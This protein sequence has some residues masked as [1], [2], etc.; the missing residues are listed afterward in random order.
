MIKGIT[1]NIERKRILAFSSFVFLSSLSAIIFTNIDKLMLGYFIQAEFIGYYTAIFSVI[2]GLL[3]LF[4]LSIVVFPVFTQIHGKRLKRAFHKTFHYLFMLT[5]PITI[6]L[7]YIFIPII[8]ILYGSVYVPLEYRTTLTITSVFLSF[9]FLE[10]IITGLYA[11]LFN[12][13]EK[14][15]L[16]ALTMIIVAILNIILNFILISY[17]IRFRPEYGLIGAAIATFASR[18]IYLGSLFVLG[19]TKLNIIPNKNSIIK[20]LTASIIMLAFL[21]IFDY[22]VPLNIFY[23]II[24]VI[25]AALIYLLIM[26]L[27]KGIKKEDIGLLIFFRKN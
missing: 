24:M 12:A 21:F 13:K 2:S 5:F 10:G 4:S 14:P 16:P 1:Q 26:F 17:F 3:G 18:Y 8:Q 9:L 23:G 11:I 7:A 25:S 22:F 27:I 6:G 15:K 20:P 19:K